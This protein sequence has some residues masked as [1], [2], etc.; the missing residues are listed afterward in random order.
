MSSSEVGARLTWSLQGLFRVAH[1]SGPAPKYLAASSKSYLDAS[2][3]GFGSLY[4]L[5]DTNPPRYFEPSSFPNSTPPV[6]PSLHPSGCW[7]VG[8]PGVPTWALS[9]P[10]LS[11]STNP[12][13]NMGESPLQSRIASRNPGAPCVVSPPLRK[14]YK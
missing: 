12:P 4:P 8:A 9:V 1:P 6:S 14:Q 3:L 5:G 10:F 2:P 11:P 13:K 7:K